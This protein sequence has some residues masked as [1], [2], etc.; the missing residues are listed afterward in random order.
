MRIILFIT[1]WDWC[2]LE[3]KPVR[4]PWT[5]VGSHLTHFTLTGRV[6]VDFSTFYFWCFH[7][8]SAAH[9]ALDNGWVDLGRHGSVAAVV[10]AETLSM[11]VPLPI[12]LWPSQNLVSTFST[13]HAIHYPLGHASRSEAFLILYLPLKCATLYEVELWSCTCTMLRV[14]APNA[15]PSYFHARFMNSNW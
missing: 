2:I 4:S 13:H 12:Q 14:D 15:I 7:F 8:V 1:N 10:K 11:S 9:S 3:L 5:D 6:P